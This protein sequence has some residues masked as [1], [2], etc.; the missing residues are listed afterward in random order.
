MHRLQYIHPIYR[1]MMVSSQILTIFVMTYFIPMTQLSKI[2]KF[3]VAR[4]TLMMKISKVSNN[5]YNIM[6]CYNNSE[7]NSCHHFLTKCQ[8]T[9]PDL[10]KNFLGG[11]GQL[12][13]GFRVLILVSLPSGDLSLPSKPKKKTKSSLLR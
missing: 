11:R 9:F 6:F 1:K 10:E 7:I 13:R 3:R 5:I 2:S 8:Y 12:G 4:C